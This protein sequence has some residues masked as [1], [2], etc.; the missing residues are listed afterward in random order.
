MTGLRARASRRTAAAAAV[1]A[2]AL[3][4]SGGVVAFAAT[5]PPAHTNNTVG[6]KQ[7][8]PIDE[9]NGFPLWYKDTSGQRLELCLKVDD[10]NCIM[11][12][13]P[14][15][16]QPLSFPDN[17]PD[18][19]FWA[20]ADAALATNGTGGKANLVT[21]L[22]AAF[23]ADVADGQQISFGR[24]RIRAEVGV[25]GAT[26]KVTHPFGVDTIVAETGAVKGLNVTEDIGDLA[27][28]STFEQ[29][30]GSRPA[31]FLKW[32]PAVAP[33]APAG[34]LGDPA[35]DHTVTGSPYD[36]NL[37]RI[38]GPAGSFPGSPDQCAN[39]GLGDS[40]TATDDCIET[41]LFSVVGKK[42]TRA[43]VQVTKAV[44]ADEAG[45][46]TLDLF[47]TS[48][49]GQKLVVSG[50]GV[51][52]TDMRGDGKGNYYARVFSGGATPTDLKVTNATD[53][54]NT[55]DHV[56]PSLFNDKV[57]INA[58]QF[59][60]DT[61]KLTVDAQSG[62]GVSTLKLEGYPTATQAPL[63]SAGR[64]L[65]SVSGLAIPP[66]DVSVSSAKGGSDSDDVVITGTDFRSNDVVASVNTNST[67]IS[68]G[69]PVTLDGTGSTGTINSFAWS[70]TQP[71]GSVLTGTG[72]SF[73]FTP[74]LVGS[75]NAK[76][77]VT[78]TGTGNTSTD[79][80]SLNVVG[81]T[82]PV[83]NAGA[84]QL[85]MAPTSTVTL[86]GSASQFVTAYA[87]T[88]PAGITLAKADTANPTFT[89]PASTTAQTYLFTLK[90]T[91]PTGATAISTVKVSSDPDDLSVD[92]AS[93]KRGGNEWRVRGTAQYCSANNTITI[94]WN[95][96]GAS[97]VVLGTITPTLAVGVCDFDY[98]LKNAPTSVRPTTAGTITV[99]SV[100]GG[101][102]TPNPA[103]Q[104]L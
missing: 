31:P 63:G 91:G 47:A 103:F 16:G 66:A 102:A 4:I 5:P 71:N 85:N 87:W 58:A 30:L 80:L 65:F 35:V 55:V 40:P 90:V 25:D 45:G 29:A 52:D 7:V 22:E 74:S 94:S 39:A 49:A 9:T 12:D 44:Y 86:D 79:N 53:S 88:A 101:Q 26:Y 73:T 3:A 60:N 62:D 2:A 6:L 11:G 75:Y 32:D 42:A 68:V 20:V 83:A 41:K 19:A 104:L 64:V 23:A 56:A 89:L 81:S 78:G 1:V 27:G 76:L 24:V 67:S 38:E 97:P 14:N 82:A 69:Q 43:G 21:A 50:A 33:A 18:E 15:P 93:F 92:S 37:F 8:G 36:T 98:R 96:P 59:D 54:P 34:Y 17:F 46:H 95:K 28:G 51:A 70:V 72:P 57:H 13:L 84:D 10:P 99:T 61:G 77:T 48:E 100:M